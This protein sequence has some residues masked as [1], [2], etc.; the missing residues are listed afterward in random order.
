MFIIIIDEKKKYENW[1]NGA[2]VWSNHCSQ[3]L[4][5]RY[6]GVC[7]VVGVLDMTGYKYLI[8]SVTLHFSWIFMHNL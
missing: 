6:M 8:T 2:V 3:G 7:S 5:H 4:Y 1:D